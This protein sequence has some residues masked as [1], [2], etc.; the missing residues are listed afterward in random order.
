MQRR[1]TARPPRLS[2]AV[3]AALVLLAL[4]AARPGFSVPGDHEIVHVEPTLGLALT[5]HAQTAVD[6]R[7]RVNPP[8][9]RPP[10]VYF[11]SRGGRQITNRGAEVFHQLH[12]A[13]R[14]EGIMSF[15]EDGV[16]KYATSDSQYIED[17]D[18]I[19]QLLG[20]HDNVVVT[21][22]PHAMDESIGALLP[23]YTGEPSLGNRTRV[24]KWQ[25]GYSFPSLSYFVDER[26]HMICDTYFLM[27]VMGCVKEAYIRAATPAAY[28]AI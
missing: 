15:L 18:E 24:I 9:E 28:P 27:D 4:P 25:I 1:A 21:A 7:P 26:Q 16:D 12:H 11:Y 6:P 14:R 8:R 22:I 2:A 13:V 20:P 5:D 17:Y 3:A 19:S 23:P 10:I